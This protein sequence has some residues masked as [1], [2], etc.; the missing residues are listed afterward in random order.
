MA[1]TGTNVRT[2]AKGGSVTNLEKSFGTTLTT[3]AFTHTNIGHH[4]GTSKVLTAA[5]TNRVDYMGL[6]AQLV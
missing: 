5:N 6:A 4:T 3:G 1:S 2:R